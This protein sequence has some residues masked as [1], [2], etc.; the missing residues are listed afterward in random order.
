M[1]FRKSV[2]TTVAMSMGCTLIQAGTT[3]T[4]AHALATPPPVPSGYTTSSASG[5]LTIDEAVI[6][7]APDL[8][9]APAGAADVIPSAAVAYAGFV[10]G[11]EVGT[12]IWSKTHEPDDAP[13][14]GAA[15][16]PNGGAGVSN[17]AGIGVENCFIDTNGFS[18]YTLSYSDPVWYS[19][20]F[21]RSDNTG[22]A[23]SDVWSGLGNFNGGTFRLNTNGWYRVP[24]YNGYDCTPSVYGPALQV[25]TLYGN[26][27][28]RFQHTFRTQVNCSNGS[29]ASARSN[30]FYESETTTPP[31]PFPTCGTGVT[32]TGIT[33][34]LDGAANDPNAAGPVVLTW[35]GPD[36][37]TVD[38]PDC[39]N[40]QCQV[41]LTRESGGVTSTCGV[42]VDCSGWPADQ[43]AYDYT[44]H[45]GP[46]VEPLAECASYRPPYPPAD[47]PIDPEVAAIMTHLD[48]AITR[49]PA[50]ANLTEDQKKQIAEEC[51]QLVKLAGSLTT[52][53]SD[54]CSQ[55]GIFA[56]GSDNPQPTAVDWDGIARGT[57]TG[58]NQAHWN[59]VLLNRKTNQTLSS[60]WKNSQENCVGATQSSP[61]DEYPFYSSSQAG[62]PAALQ[63]VD[64]GQNSSEGG[65]LSSFYTRCGIQDGTP[66]LVLPMVSSTAPPTFSVCAP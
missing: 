2:L 62:Y 5:T 23:C 51:L 16:C 55:G 50:P 53:W 59:W 26:T 61:C 36:P 21:Y 3:L 29:S 38:H 52:P 19:A 15:K 48:D 56:P 37:A 24:V 46:Y 34:W 33:V 42:D 63:K 22:G 10:V 58:D 35:S 64:G 11:F 9:V 57:M 43:A 54:P 40:G 17:M 4:S 25:A 14:R 18:T 49:G 66:F 41:Y 6:D 65:L 32:E 20:K 1:R 7:L 13:P 60:K 47:V 45:W 27:F 30:P 44:C 28:P 31:I 8:P 12:W 39:L